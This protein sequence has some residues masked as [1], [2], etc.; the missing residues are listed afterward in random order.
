MLTKKNDISRFSA[1]LVLLLG[2]VTGG[3]LPLP[4]L[5][6]EQADIQSELQF[7]SELIK[8]RFPDYAQKA[9][10]RLLIRYPAAKAEAAK[11]RVE[12]LTSR[13]KFDEAEALLK[14]MPAGTPETM[15]IQLAIADQYYAWK[16]MKDAERVY[17]DFFKQFPKGPPE[18]V[19]R[20][21]GESAYKFSQ[22]LLLSG[23]LKGALEA[24][25]RVL[26]CPLNSTE[27]ERRVKTEMAELCLRVAQLPATTA[28]EKK[29]ILAEAEKKC[30]EVQ[31]KGTDLWF[32]KTVVILAHIRMLNGDR[33]GARRAITDYLPMLM[34]VDKMLRDAKENMKLSPMA[35]C[36]FLLG[37]LYED[38]G[39]EIVKVKAQEADGIKMLKQAM[40]QLYSVA[41]NYPGS[42]WAPEARRRADAI[43]DMLVND[44]GKTVVKPEFDSTQM[45]TEQLKEA[46]LLFQQQDFKNAVEKYVDILNI[47][48]VFKEAPTAVGE[49]ARSYVELKDE[50]YARAMAEFLAER[51]CQTTNQYE[52]AGNALLAVASAYDDRRAW[53]QSESIYQLYY[54]RYPNHTKVPFILFRQGDVAL[55]ATNTVEALQNFQRIAE[56]YPRARVYPDALSRQAYCMSL[57]GDHT[58]AIPVLTNYIAQLSAGVEMLSARLR[59]ADEYR[60]ADMIVAALNEYAR[61]QKQ[62]SQEGSSFTGT[63]EDATRVKKIAEL[64]LYSKAQCYTRLRE[65]A[66]QVPLYQAKA[67]EGYELFLKDYPKSEFAPS[68]LG[69][70]GTLYYLL[71]KPDEAGKTFDRLAKNYPESQQAL[72]MVFVRA[73]SLMNMGE[74]AKAVT[75]YAEMAKTP[76]LFNASQF[77][78][79]GRV[80]LDAQ[81]F[82]T[83]VLLLAEAR[84]SKDVPL[85]QGA[86]VAM[87]WA[88]AGAGKFEEAVK[89][90]EDFLRKYQKSGYVIDVNLAL[91]RCYAELA[92][93]LSDP[94]QSKD[95]F[96]K[97]FSAMGKVR[98]YSR[99]PDMM[100]KADIEMAGIQVLMG[101][102]MGALASYQRI[103]LFV[104]P[105]NVKV[106]PHVETAFDRSLPLFRE[107]GKMDGLQ[108]ACETYIKQF[109]QGQFIVKARQGRDEAKAKLASGR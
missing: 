87:G 35:E 84:K 105:S 96:K 27:I 6:D 108:E 22:M 26:T 28:S 30:Q 95:L 88:L 42:S 11:V 58:N 81:E 10:D 19:A 3:G 1:G 102:K 49:L 67:I 25:R 79:A 86:T 101:D 5:A 62:I 20:F 80:L 14:T 98:Q 85:W 99:E 7:A 72:N 71:N 74:K 104:D 53:L 82:E 43:V 40:S 69:A 68:I 17:L 36:K 92:K 61:L 83:A 23:D 100:V 94:Q 18:N 9:M 55:R 45:V 78:R 2:V 15:V 46:R 97:A 103:L 52:E 51:F 106:R 63:P 60:S 29:V 91:S 54:Q 34:D 13:G 33:A 38:E 50:P 31:W 107:T 70:M 59:L 48:D 65:P 64:A 24:Y 41:K 109:P 16:K 47:T 39:R 89:V 37:T 21:Y 75:V 12:V 32:A 56:K 77:L 73:D 8:W 90:L 44:L 93:K 57:Q 4:V 66:N 76:Q